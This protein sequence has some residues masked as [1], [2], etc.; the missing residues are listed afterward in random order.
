MREYDLIR[1]I[2]DRFPSSPNQLNEPFACDAEVIRL[3]G[4]L[5]GLTLDDFSQDED[6]LFFD[7]PAVLG[8]NLA[9]AT[10]SDLLAAGCEP[11]FFMH[12]LCL[13]KEVDPLL[14]DSLLEGIKAVLDEAGCFLCGGDV[15]TASPWRYSGFAMGRVVKE[16]PLTH[17]IPRERHTLHVT[18]TLGDA[19]VAA[20]HRRAAPLFELRLEEARLIQA[21]G[22]GCIDTSGGFLDAAWLLLEQSP[23]MRLEIDE[24]K[25][26]LEPG[27]REELS[28]A[29]IP[30]GAALL[31]GAGEYELLFAIPGSAPV[32]I[33]EAIEQADCAAVGA[34]VPHEEAG[35]FI[36][37]LDG[38]WIAMTEPPPC[39]R[40]A[41]T[42]EGHVREVL[43][44]A[45]AL[46]GPPVMEQEGG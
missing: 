13:P 23:G 3:N 36:R 46:F 34:A 26:P 19:N 4:R 27:I 25:I 24:A 15:G 39:P 38:T 41:A 32:E 31:G 16:K 20:L 5:Y 45:Q 2:A 18:G 21:H 8:R 40:G 7:D 35:L 29:G 17:R 9:T 44:A 11:E 22:T 10:L 30:P 6:L 37:R 33:R 12:A 14:I 28:K 42:T 43:E 1:R